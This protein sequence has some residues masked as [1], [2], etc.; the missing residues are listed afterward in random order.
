MPYENITRA[1]KPEGW[2]QSVSHEKENAEQSNVNSISQC[3]V[4][5]GK[6]RTSLMYSKE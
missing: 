5:I 6:V 2:L 4:S 1:S 3:V